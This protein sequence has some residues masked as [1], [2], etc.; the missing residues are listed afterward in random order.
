MTTDSFSALEQLA[1][2]AQ[3]QCE[4]GT[5]NA[6]PRCLALERFQ[7]ITTTDFIL[8]CIEALRAADAIPKAENDYDYAVAASMYLDRR[9]RLDN[10]LKERI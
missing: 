5:N 6:C 3:Q 7:E 10:L 1:K 4:F 9:A 8:A 2:A